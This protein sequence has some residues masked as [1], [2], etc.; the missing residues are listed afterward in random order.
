MA[1]N[2]DPDRLPLDA[3]VTRMRDPTFA[4]RHRRRLSLRSTSA[5]V[6]PVML[7]VC[8]RESLYVREWRRHADH[9]RSCASIFS[10]FGIPV[11]VE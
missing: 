2:Q 7:A 8:S 1:S 5:H 10:Y 11:D 6:N 9:C 3:L 4:A